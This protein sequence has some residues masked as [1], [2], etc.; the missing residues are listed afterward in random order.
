MDTALWITWYDLP[1]DRRAEYLSWTHETYIPELL[2]RSGYLWAAHF[3]TVDKAQR[4]TTA[5]EA[6]LNRTDDASIPKGDR[7]ILLVGAESAAV[8]GNPVP[9]A[10]HAGLPVDC[11]TMLAMR[12]GERMNIMAE[13][14]RVEGPAAKD[15][16]DGPVLAP[17]IQL[18]NYS[19]PWQHEEEMLAWYTQWRMPQMARLPGCIRTRRLASLAGWAKHAVLY[20]FVSLEARNQYYTAHEDAHPEMKAWSNRL[21]PKLIHAPGSSYLA[22][23]IWPEVSN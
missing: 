23:R 21:V 7:Y 2:K 17:C 6:V 8:F 5:R 16:K 14:Q 3:A 1:P 22:R 11:R 15:Y 13:F 12:L 18:G 4:P 19:C 20:E 9:G 10:L